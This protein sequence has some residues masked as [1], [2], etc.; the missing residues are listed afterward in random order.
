M[1]LLD[2]TQGSATVTYAIDAATHRVKEV[3]AG[4]LGTVTFR[5]LDTAPSV[6]TPSPVCENPAQELDAKALKAFAGGTVS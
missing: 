6:E 2:A 5:T 4:A 3:R 1:I